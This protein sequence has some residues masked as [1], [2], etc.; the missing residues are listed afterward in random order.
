MKILKKKKGKGVE[1]EGMR[2]KEDVMRMLKIEKE[3]EGN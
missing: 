3:N 2:R 1:Y